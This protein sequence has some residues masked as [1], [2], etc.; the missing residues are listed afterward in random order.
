MRVEASDGLAIAGSKCPRVLA[1]IRGLRSGCYA[2]GSSGS[3][4]EQL[5]RLPVVLHRTPLQHGGNHR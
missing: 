2:P 1:G 4:L 3:L 5:Q